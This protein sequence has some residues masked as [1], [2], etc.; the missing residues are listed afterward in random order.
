MKNAVSEG[1]ADT[2]HEVLLDSYI[3]EGFAE[4]DSER[5]VEQP[6]PEGVAE[7]NHEG[8]LD[9]HILEWVADVESVDVDQERCTDR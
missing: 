2:T 7:T 4:M 1:V 9:G 5:L 8:L 3:L 6:A